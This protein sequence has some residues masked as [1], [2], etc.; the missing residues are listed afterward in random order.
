MLKGHGDGV[1]VLTRAML[2]QV[3]TVRRVVDGAVLAAGVIGPKPYGSSMIMKACPFTPYRLVFRGMSISR[4]NAVVGKCRMIRHSR[5]KK[6]EPNPQRY[7][8]CSFIFLLPPLGG[9]SLQEWASP[10]LKGKGRVQS[11]GWVGGNEVQ[12]FNRFFFS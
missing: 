6:N 4:P 12:T 3:R 2:G 9:D 7:V 8:L 10:C 11:L 5:D 1:W